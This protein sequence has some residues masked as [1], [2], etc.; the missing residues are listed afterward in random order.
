M[1]EL[2]SFLIEGHG[3]TGRWWARH[4]PKRLRTT[5]IVQINT[6]WNIFRGCWSENTRSFCTHFRLTALSANNCRWNTARTWSANNCYLF[7][8]IDSWP[9]HLT[10]HT[11]IVDPFAVCLNYGQNSHLIVGRRWRKEDWRWYRCVINTA[12][13]MD[14]GRAGNGNQRNRAVNEGPNQQRR[15]RRQRS[16]L[17]CAASRRRSTRD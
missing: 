2:T 14:A 15:R 17:T 1:G 8:Q 16:N 5:D 4:G 9:N 7:A 6:A 10:M 3:A 11:R 13:K 12:A